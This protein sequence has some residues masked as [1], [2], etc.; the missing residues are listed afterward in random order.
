MPVKVQCGVRSAQS[1]YTFRPSHER[2]YAPRGVFTAFPWA[3]KKGKKPIPSFSEPF[4]DFFQGYD[5]F[6][7]GQKDRGIVPERRL[8]ALY[9]GFI[10]ILGMVVSIFRYALGHYKHISAIF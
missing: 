10:L 7:V 9:P 5:H 6:F 1:I 8:R 2:L 3:K 4:R